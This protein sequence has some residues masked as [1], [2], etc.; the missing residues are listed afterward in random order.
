MLFLCKKEK[1]PSQ[2]LFR[3]SKIQ[4]KFL[5]DAR[6]SVVYSVHDVGVCYAEVIL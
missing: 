4:V 6:V 2:F 1:K 5:F 3:F